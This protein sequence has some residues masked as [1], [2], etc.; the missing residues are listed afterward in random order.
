MY[1]PMFDPTMIL[2]IPGIIV[3]MYAQS[4]VQTTFARYSR[5]LSQRGITGAQ[6]SQTN[7]GQ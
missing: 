7:P 1:Y 2:L 6:S 3:A 4:K 5:V